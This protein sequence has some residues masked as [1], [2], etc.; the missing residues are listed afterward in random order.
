MEA[1]LQ[2]ALPADHGIGAEIAGAHHDARRRGRFLV[3]QHVAAV[4]GQRQLQQRAG[5]AR[6]GLDQ[7]EQA[8]RGH[9]Q[10]RQRAAQ[11]AG[12]FAHEPVVRMAFQ[13]GVGGQDAVGVALGLEDPGADVQF[14]G[15]H[16]QDGVVQ[17]ARHLQRPPGRAGRQDIG[18]FHGCVALGRAHGPDGQALVAVD[19]HV[20]V[21]VGQAIGAFLAVQRRQRDALR[22]GR[23]VAALRQGLRAFAHGL[24]ET[25]GL[26]HLVHQPPVLGALAAHAFD[27][28]AENVGM[29]VAHLALVGHAGQSAGAGQHAQQR[30]FGQ[31]HGR[32]AVVDQHDFVAGQR[33]LVA[34][35]GA[36]A[37]ERGDELQAAVAAGVLDAVAGFVG[38][39]AE[40]H[41]PGMRGQAQHEDVGARTEDAFLHA[42]DHH[43]AH[44][45]VLEADALQRVV[46]FDVDAQVVGIQLELVAGAQA[47]VFGHVHGQRG[48]RAVVAQAPMTV[49]A[50]I[51]PEIYPVESAAHRVSPCTPRQ[52]KYCTT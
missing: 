45:G 52:E 46:Q 42:G 43:A 2:A 34:A 32:R 29:V 39:L 41:L 10:A 12:G 19:A 31:R 48:N 37:V 21:A 36:G 8:A 6:A 23:A 22:I 27:Q 26:D 14:V 24:L 35:A 44:F 49:L 47:A 4:R 1:P 5:K 38:E 7:R 28:G 15:A 50:G 20:D 13:R 17:F 16:G 11:H 18:D 25:G 9:V 33:Q 30:H 3:V 40:V 51:G